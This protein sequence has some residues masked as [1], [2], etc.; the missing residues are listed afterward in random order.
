ARITIIC[1]GSSWRDP[2]GWRA[3]SP[4]IALILTSAVRLK[5]QPAGQS[6]LTDIRLLRPLSRCGGSEPLICQA[7]AIIAA[8]PGDRASP[9]SGSGIRTVDVLFAW[10]E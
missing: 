8:E 3:D 6:R 1:L 2:F 9:T 10:G 7:A 4:V 5:R